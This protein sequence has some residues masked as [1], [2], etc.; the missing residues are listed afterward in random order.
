MAYF[1]L[2]FYLV[3]RH[4]GGACSTAWGAGLTATCANA[5]YEAL[6]RQRFLKRFGASSV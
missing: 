1:G 6:E 5:H 2:A 4:H 3:D